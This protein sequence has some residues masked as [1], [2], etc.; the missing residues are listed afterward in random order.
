MHAVNEG[1]RKILLKGEGFDFAAIAS[2]PIELIGIESLSV[3][4]YDMH[5]A[6]LSKNIVVVEGL[7]LE[8]VPKGSYILFALPIK[9]GIDG[10]PAR[11]VLVDTE[12]GLL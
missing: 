2:L 3:G 5:R 7:L 9:T 8:D 4:D 1:I 10:S 11:V 12:G 6:Y